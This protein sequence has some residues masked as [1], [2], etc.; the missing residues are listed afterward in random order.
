MAPSACKRSGRESVRVSAGFK[1]DP[2]GEGKVPGQVDGAG[3]TPHIDFPGIGTGLPAAAGILFA[4]EGPAY[5]GPR[6]ADIDIGDAAVRS[7]RTQE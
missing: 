4:S 3:L 1:A 5:F 7:L 6:S 2:L